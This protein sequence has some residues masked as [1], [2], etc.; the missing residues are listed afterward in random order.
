MAQLGANHLRSN[1][2]G[3]NNVVVHQNSIGTENGK[4]CRAWVNFNGTGA[5][6]IRSS[7]NISSITDNGTGNYTINFINALSDANFSAIFAGSET[8][9][10]GTGSRI[11]TAHR[12]ETTSS[13][14]TE[15]VGGDGSAFD[16]IKFSCAIFR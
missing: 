14:R 4:L 2:S 3:F 7:F 11:F 9:N 13:V 1:G 10:F 12:T 15:S 8:V 5:V 16:A 6:A